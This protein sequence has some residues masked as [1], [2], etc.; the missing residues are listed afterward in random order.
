MVVFPANPFYSIA[1]WYFFPYPGTTWHSCALPG[2]PLYVLVARVIPGFSQFVFS[3]SCQVRPNILQWYCRRL[4]CTKGSWSSK[5]MIFL[6][7]QKELSKNPNLFHSSCV[8]R[9][10]ASPQTKR[11][12]Y[13]C[14]Y[15]G[16]GSKYDC[17]YSGKMTYLVL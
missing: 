9:V 16:L 1:F 13:P 17:H 7:T 6:W 2:I 3:P 4:G 8:F 11:T 5:N 14:Y 15:R 12:Q 10:S